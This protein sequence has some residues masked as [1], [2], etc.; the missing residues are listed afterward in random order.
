MGGTGFGPAR[1]VALTGSASTIL[2]GARLARTAALGGD[3]G[4]LDLPF[5]Q[6]GHVD[7]SFVP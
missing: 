7:F 1:K 4:G 5:C 2:A 6:V 3:F